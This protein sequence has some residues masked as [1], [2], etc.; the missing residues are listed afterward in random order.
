MSQN[1][2]H[3]MGLMGSSS[4]V[5]VAASAAMAANEAGRLVD[6]VQ[7]DWSVAETLLPFELKEGEQLCST[8]KMDLAPQMDLELAL[9]KQAVALYMP[10]HRTNCSASGSPVHQPSIN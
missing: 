4:Y 6:M 8:W 2:C 10:L 7:R 9:H 3:R 5:A 1:W